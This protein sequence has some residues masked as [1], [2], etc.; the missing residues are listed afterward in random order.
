VRA[1]RFVSIVALGSGL[2]AGAAGAAPG[3]SLT[4][5]AFSAAAMDA[6]VGAF[7][8]R[9]TVGE[10]GSLG[11]TAGGSYR[12]G[13]G[14]WAPV[15]FLGA[16]GAGPAAPSAVQ[17]ADGLAQAFP[18]P[19]RDAATFQYTV[20]RQARVSLQVYD[21]TGRRIA[22]LVDE[23]RA[24]GRHTVRWDGRDHTGRT[25]TTGVYFYRIRIGPW[26]DSKRLLRLR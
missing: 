18:N 5:T 16:T 23:E 6:A 11:A 19:F 8:L 1:A 9:G 17:W 21:V 4:R 10:A 12:L 26:S 25:V 20:A 24:P 22:T 14:F 15:F 13:T 2:V 7:A 3:V